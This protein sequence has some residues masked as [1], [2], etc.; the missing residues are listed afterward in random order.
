MVVT[1]RHLGRVRLL[2]EIVTLPGDSGVGHRGRLGGVAD[3]ARI[4]GFGR[5]A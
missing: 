2:L 3:A 4:L 1:S 5:L